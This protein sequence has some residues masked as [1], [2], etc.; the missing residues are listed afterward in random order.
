MFLI[1]ISNNVSGIDSTTNSMNSIN[2]RIDNIEK[3]IARYD[4]NQNY[5]QT[6]INTQTTI[7]V[8]IVTIALTFVVWFGLFYNKDRIQ[9]MVIESEIN[10]AKEKDKVLG[11]FYKQFS[12]INKHWRISNFLYRVKS[13]K[14]YADAGYLIESNKELI[15]IYEEY[16]IDEGK[17]TT[18]KT[19]WEKEEMKPET[20]EINKVLNDLN[21]SIEKEILSNTKKEIQ[22]NT[23]RIIER[24]ESN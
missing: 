7:F 12:Q 1:I 13:A 5:F 18:L 21:T 22:L 6:A 17:R 4:I 14:H 20:S 16:F 2:A 3:T 15:S 10:I 9:K 24:I 19:D 11:D 8:L 23:N